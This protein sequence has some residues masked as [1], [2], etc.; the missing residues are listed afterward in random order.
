MHFLHNKAG[1]FL[2]SLL[3]AVLFILPAKAE[4]SIH[5]NDLHDK[6][7]GMWLAQLIGNMAGRETEGHF[8][9][10]SPNLASSVPWVIRVPYPS[11][12]NDPNFWEG[13]DD[14]DIEYVALHILEANSLDCNSQEIADQW[15]NHVS[16]TY[17]SG[18]YIANRQ[19]WYLMK[20][21]FIPPETGSRTY[22]EHWYSIDAQITTESLGAICPAM[23]Q[24]AIEL[25]DRFAQVTNEGFPVH[26]AQFYAAMYTN[27]FFE[28]NV[29]TLVT[30]GLNAI[31]TTSR[32]HE[33]IT[34]VLNWYIEDANDGDLD[35][36]QT[37]KK[38]TVHSNFDN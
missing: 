2:F 20:D 18:I 10:S 19:A 3:I 23:P 27:A 25:T 28:P 15:L 9:G 4:K 13:D 12:S 1:T 6:I 29:I 35:W 8:S 30:E 22:N 38:V 17:A 14:T 32:T 34:D 7:H 21:G 31:P 5:L 16:T 26:T 36:T 33:V 37:R 11:D 24:R